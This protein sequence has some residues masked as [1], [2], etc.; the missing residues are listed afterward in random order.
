[1]I[2][3]AILASILSSVIGTAALAGPEDFTLSLGIDSFSAFGQSYDQIWLDIE[4][5]P[6][7]FQVHGA[8]IDSATTDGLPVTG[9]CAFGGEAIFCTLGS[10]PFNM[11]LDMDAELNGQF[12]VEDQQTNEIGEGSVTFISLE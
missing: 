8:V 6:R 4:Q 1:M 12:V 3:Q 10:F 5:T 2:K 9:T 11:W 7:F